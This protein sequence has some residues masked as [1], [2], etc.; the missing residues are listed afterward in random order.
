MGLIYKHVDWGINRCF[1]L[2]SGKTRERSFV[3]N[4]DLKFENL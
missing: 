2:V 4:I 3:C 1:S